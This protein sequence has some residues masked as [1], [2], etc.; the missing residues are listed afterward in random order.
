MERQGHPPEASGQQAFVRFGNHR[1][2][3]PAPVK[4]NWNAAQ[5]SPAREPAQHV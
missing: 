2:L 1:G 4:R 5:A 3:S